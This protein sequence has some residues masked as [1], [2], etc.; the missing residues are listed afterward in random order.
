MRFTKLYATALFALAACFI[1]CETDV[2]EIKITP[3]GNAMQREVMAYTNSD[4]TVKKLDDK[5]LEPLV[6]VYGKSISKPEATTQVFRGEFADKMPQDIGGYGAYKRFPT[7]LG[8]AYFYVEQ[9][10]GSAHP[11]AKLD[12]LTKTI[13]NAVDLLAG[14]LEAELGKEKGFDPLHAYVDKDIRAML[15]DLK[16]YFYFDQAGPQATTQASQPLNEE[17]GVRAAVRVMQTDLVDLEQL[18][19]LLYRSDDIRSQKALSLAQRKIAQKMG[20]PADK[21]IPASLTF[22]DTPEKAAAS[23]EKYARTTKQWQEFEKEV[24]RKRAIAATQ[25]TQPAANQTTQATQSTQPEDSLG[26]FLGYTLLGKTFGESAGNQEDVILTLALPH[27]PAK[28]NG[29]WEA[30][31]GVVWRFTLSGSDSLAW[32]RLAYAAWVKPDK[33][34]QTKLFEQEALTGEELQSYAIIRAGMSKD[35]SAKWLIRLAELTPKS[36]AQWKKIEGNKD[37][38]YGSYVNEEF[39]AFLQPSTQPSQPATAKN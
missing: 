6:K 37:R 32:P 21:P 12:E 14:W 31:K 1:G 34:A 25:A 16:L 20:I 39:Q 28:T 17:L 7:E 23:F 24:A 18:V 33:Q 4:K 27:E 19:N 13:D 3:H 26:A 11:A 8:T 9:F 2:Y 15:Q 30:S 38:P 36:Y 5:R 35:Q 10:R 29:T 22:L